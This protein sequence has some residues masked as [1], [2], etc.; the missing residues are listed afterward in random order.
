M[1]RALI[2]VSDKTNIVEF[3]KSLVE[4]D[5][6]IVSTGGTFKM[7]KEAGVAAIEI[8]EVTKFPECFEGRVK[9][10]NTF[11]HGAILNRRDKQSHLDQAKELCVEAIDLV[12]VNL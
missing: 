1:K 2:S 3:A 10:L 11:V 4:L 7:L 9:T 12:C 8:D 6:E 5:F